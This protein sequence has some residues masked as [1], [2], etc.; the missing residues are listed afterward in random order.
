MEPNYRKY[1]KIFGKPV[2]YFY[3]FFLLSITEQV[4]ARPVP[5]VTPTNTSALKIEAEYLLTSGPKSCPEGN[6]TVQKNSK[7]NSRTLIFG[8][9]HSW[10]LNKESQGQTKETVEG[11]CTYTT[12]Y[13]LSETGF[14][15]ETHRQACPDN[16]ENAIIQE[17]LELNQKKLTY[18]YQSVDEK[19]FK[20]E[21]S[22]QYD[23]K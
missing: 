9:R 7:D 12:K 16:T 19:K 18:S 1:F 22:C 17:K 6:I 15:V 4:N 11:G 21:I 5:S 10:I 2:N 14:N 8:G 13:S 3:L 23:K 20:E